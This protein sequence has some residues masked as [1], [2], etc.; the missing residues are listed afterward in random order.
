[1]IWERRE[2]RSR[3]DYTLG[4]DCRLFGDVS[5]RDTRHNSDHCM[6]LGFLHSAS[7]REHTRYLGVCKRLPLLPPTAPTREDRIFAALWR[8]A[9]KPRAW[10][11][12]KN[13]WISLTTWILIDERVSVR[14]DIAKDQALIRMLGCAIKA[15]LREDR[16]WRAEEA[17]AEV[18]ALLG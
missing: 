4:T 2:V 14:Q 10:E 7:L 5:V 15:I 6:V 3:T 17:G 8:A 1:M 16:K 18:E 11:A 13:A 12:R 9:L